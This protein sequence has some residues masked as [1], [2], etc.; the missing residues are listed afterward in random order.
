M[1]HP[2]SPPDPTKPKPEDEFE[3]P[4]NLTEEEKNYPVLSEEEIDAMIARH[5]EWIRDCYKEYAESMKAEWIDFKTKHANDPRRANFSRKKL[6]KEYWG[7]EKLEGSKFYISIFPNNAILQD[8]HLEYTYLRGAHLEYIYLRGAHLENADLRFAHLENAN[9]TQAH[10]ENV[11]LWG[12]YLENANLRFAHFKNTNLTQA[13]LEKVEIECALLL[14]SDLSYSNL[15]SVKAQ[16]AK[17]FGINFFCAK[18]R[19]CDFSYCEFRN[20]KKPAKPSNEEEPL[21]DEVETTGLHDAQFSDCDL[22]GAHLP[23]G[24]AKFEFLNTINESTKSN[25][26]LFFQLMLFCVTIPFAI[27]LKINP[28]PLL[29]IPIK[30]SYLAP[31]GFSLILYWNFHVL[32]NLQRHWEL[33]D[34]LP[35]RFPDGLSCTKRIQPWFVND[36]M[37]EHRSFPKERSERLPPLYWLEYWMINGVVWWVA[38][39]ALLFIWVASTSTSNEWVLLLFN[40]GISASTVLAVH[41]RRQAIS[42]LTTGKRAIFLDFPMELWEEMKKKKADKKTSYV[43]QFMTFDWKKRWQSARPILEIALCVVLLVVFTVVQKYCANIDR[44]GIPWW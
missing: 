42:T 25:R 32:L 37:L 10:L 30:L 26:K 44:Y 33:L 21:P 15:L 19:S 41:S 7:Y 39:I 16:R 3:W 43:G 4:E 34:H 6:A 22:A 18:I 11:D 17:F 36:F 2:D 20:W 9:L 12:A 35:A 23:E 28:I 13:H 38:P 27:L 5:Q 29:G 14:C 24:V 1:S 40:F 8:A 31:C